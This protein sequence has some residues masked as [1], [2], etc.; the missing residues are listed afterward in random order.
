MIHVV[1]LGPG[2][3]SLLT[4]A[5]WQ[6]IVGSDEVVLRTGKHQVADYM[7]EHGVSFS[8]C[9]QYYER[10]TSFDD[11][12]ESITADLLTKAGQC[13]S[14]VYAVPGH[15][16]V[17]E[18][19]VE[20]LL[21]K[22]RLAGIPTVV[23]AGISSLEAVYA[24]LEID[25]AYGLAVADALAPWLIPDPRRGLLI[26]QAYNRLVAGDIKLKLLE[27]YPPLHPVTTVRQAG[28]AECE[29]RITPLAELD[30]YEFSYADTVYVPPCSAARHAG[31]ELGILQDI[32]HRL[33][34]VAGCPWDR[35]QTHLTLRPYLVEET[36]EVL[37]AIDEAAPD[38]LAEELGDLLLQVVFHATI[39]D[40]AGD[41]ALADSIR[42]INEKLIRRHPHVFG[43]VQV[44]NSQQVVHNWQ[45][46]KLTEKKGEQ[47]VRLLASVPRGLPALQQ[48]YKM[49]DR[50][51]R[52][53]FDWP[54]IDG[55]LQKLA[56]ELAEF[57]QARAT[58]S[59]EAM[60]DELGDVLFSL[61]NVSRFVEIEPETALRQA[62][63]KFRRRFEAV[64][65]RARNQGLALGACS[66]QELDRL[67]D[68]VKLE[69]K[70]F[71]Y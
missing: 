31:V 43:E 2:E 61:V 28:T 57:A 63:S 69:E 42:H 41:F 10:E 18:R 44:E 62:N 36:Y 12:Y 7:R 4:L 35:E 29:V 45:K 71:I 27:V 13:H 15:P 58:G 46:I 24:K 38:K 40:E 64:E 5:A 16:L 9:D 53:G 66:L 3:P 6:A 33:R 26:T 34:S 17:A 25:P 48:A 52:A 8:T 50:A 32:M 21:S 68:E 11:V 23:V 60:L 51:R 49:Q 39:A 67:W 19:T 54:S 1:G 55:A 22:A 56:E 70:Q 37:E 20:L 30:H 14:L 65:I 59:K 47:E